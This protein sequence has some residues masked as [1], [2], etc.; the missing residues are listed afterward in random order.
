MTDDKNTRQVVDAVGACMSA[1]RAIVEWAEELKV[2]PYCEKDTDK[3]VCSATCIIADARA[4]IYTERRLK[5]SEQIV[6]VVNK[7]TRERDEARREQQMHEGAFAAAQD[8]H[9]QRRLA[10]EQV[11]ALRADVGR[12]TRE[13]DAMSTKAEVERL[14]QERDDALVSSGDSILKAAEALKAWS[15]ACEKARAEVERLRQDNEHLALA[16]EGIHHYRGCSPD[17]PCERCRAEQAEAALANAQAQVAAMRERGRILLG[18]LAEMN[19]D[20]RCGDIDVDAIDDLRAALATD[21]PRTVT[22]ET[23][24]MLV[25]ALRSITGPD[26]EAWILRAAF[27]KDLC[28]AIVTALAAAEREMGGGS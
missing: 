15:E 14:R 16:C 24:R 28:D 6:G 9:A 26:G 3:S 18:V 21:A 20:D 8:A 10:E 4:T 25:E 23:A 1:L 5:A 2:C 17:H 27:R 12:L 22:P 7:L 19:E 11:Y 13:L